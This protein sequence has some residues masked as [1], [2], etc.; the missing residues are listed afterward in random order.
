[1]KETDEWEVYQAALPKMLAE[2]DAAKKKVNRSKGSA[3]A[4][5][6]NQMAPQAASVWGG[7]S[8]SIMHNTFDSGAPSSNLIRQTTSSAPA[9]TFVPAP[10][11]DTSSIPPAPAA[12][13]SATS[14]PSTRPDADIVSSI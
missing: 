5:E 1:M 8:G 2:I 6:G 11:F 7:S 13:R 9:P 10:T 4:L 3:V 14:Y 12:P